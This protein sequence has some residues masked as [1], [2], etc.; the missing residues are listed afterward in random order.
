[1]QLVNRRD[2]APTEGEAYGDYDY[3]SNPVAPLYRSGW[4][5]PRL[6]SSQQTF[7][8][9]GSKSKTVRSSYP[10]PACDTT[11]QGRQR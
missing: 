1:M 2:F 3:T 9:W 8:R 10:I 7:D 11:L 4:C 6:V 5:M